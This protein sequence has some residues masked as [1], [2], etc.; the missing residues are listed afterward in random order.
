MFHQLGTRSILVLRNSLR[1]PSSRRKNNNNSLPLLLTT[2]KGALK[3]RNS[4]PTPTPLFWWSKRAAERGGRFGRAPFLVVKRGGRK[5]WQIWPRPFLMVKKGWQKFAARP[6]LVV[7]TGGQ[8][9]KRGRSRYVQ[10]GKPLTISITGASQSIIM[11]QDNNAL[12]K[13]TQSDF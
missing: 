11:Q 12:T 8:I 9:M 3:H 10:N 5:G 1:T 4:T 7:K 2:T 6:F 13:A